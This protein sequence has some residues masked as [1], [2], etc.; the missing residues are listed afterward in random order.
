[1]RA[2]KATLHLLSDPLIVNHNW[3]MLS[4]TLHQGVDETIIS[5]WGSPSFEE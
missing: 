1:M 4:H 5:E 3:E 2:W